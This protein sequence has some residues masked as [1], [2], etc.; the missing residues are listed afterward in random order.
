MSWHLL[1]KAERSIRS[2]F[3]VPGSPGGGEIQMPSFFC[4]GKDKGLGK[5]I[6]HCCVLT[7]M[8]VSL[9][10][11]SVPPSFLI[12]SKCNFESWNFPSV[13]AP[14]VFPSYPR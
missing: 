8:L 9:P 2:C 14:F 3:G 10:D 1:Y 7:D 11:Q 6:N 5:G 4:A 13:T 12:S